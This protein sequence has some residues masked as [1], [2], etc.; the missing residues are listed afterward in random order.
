[1]KPTG[2][3]PKSFIFPPIAPNIETPPFRS[4]CIGRLTGVNSDDQVFLFVNHLFTVVSSMYQTLTSVSYSLDTSATKRN[5][6]LRISSAFFS[7]VTFAKSTRQ[8]FT[9]FSVYS[10][11]S[12]VAEIL[13]LKSSKILKLRC[14]RV[15][16]LY[17]LRISQLVQRFSCIK[18]S[19]LLAPCR[20]MPSCFH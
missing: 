19:F 12:R 16:C 18:V 8:Y 7:L 1:M 10:L 5:C 13:T 20:L 4:G 2:S 15:K 6:Y 11:Y 9:P 17:Q 14:L 3:P